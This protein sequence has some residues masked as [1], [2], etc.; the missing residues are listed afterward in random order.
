MLSK[1]V[2][3]LKMNVIIVATKEITYFFK[4]VGQR[5]VIITLILPSLL[6]VHTMHS[7]YCL[8]IRH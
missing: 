7:I 6:D 5:L 3:L 8:S 2:S 4:H 1:K